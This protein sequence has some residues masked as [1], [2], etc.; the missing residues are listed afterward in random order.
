MV[1]P[2][3]LSFIF[4]HYLRR[5]LMFTEITHFLCFSTCDILHTMLFMKRVTLPNRSVDVD[6]HQELFA[7]LVK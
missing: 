2:T 3:S 1:Q 5:L 4:L 6:S 7:E